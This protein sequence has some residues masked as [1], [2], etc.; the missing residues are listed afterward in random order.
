MVSY[1]CW[2]F[3]IQMVLWCEKFSLKGIMSYSNHFHPHTDNETKFTAT[4]DLRNFHTTE[5]EAKHL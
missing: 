4:K 2:I 1:H 5:A 3:C